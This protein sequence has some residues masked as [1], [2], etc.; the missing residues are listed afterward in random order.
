V[1]FDN[2]DWPSG[3]VQAWN[4][5]VQVD[6][7]NL[8]PHRRPQPDVV[9]MTG[10]SASIPIAK[11]APLDESVIVRTLP[12]IDGRDGGNRERNLG[13]DGRLEDSL[14]PDQGHADAV[15]VE[16]PFED[17]SRQGG[18]AE[19]LLLFAQEV[20]C[21]QSDRGVE[22]VNHPR[23]ANHPERGPASERP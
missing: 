22:V 23:S 4:D 17:T 20:E 5:P 19:A 3:L 13:Q 11:E 2:E 8:A 15:K 18:A 10:V 21:A 12:P 6:E 9:P 7:R 16:S 1:V 14:R